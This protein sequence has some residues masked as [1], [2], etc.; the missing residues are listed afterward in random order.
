[1][2]DWMDLARVLLEARADPNF[3]VSPSFGSAM[4]AVTSC[5]D[6]VEVG[7]RPSSSFRGAS[8]A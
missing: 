7:A 3:Y 1:M 2:D 8:P 6:S 4:R 5:H